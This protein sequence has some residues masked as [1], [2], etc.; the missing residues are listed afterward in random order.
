MLQRTHV[1][2]VW[3]GCLVVLVLFLGA[4][5]AYGQ[6]AEPT[7][8]ES[9]PTLRKAFTASLWGF[10]ASM[11]ADVATSIRVFRLSGGREANPIL[12]WAPQKPVLFTVVMTGQTVAAEWLLRK[13]YRDRPRLASMT[14]MVLAGLHGWAAWH[15]VRVK[16]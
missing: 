9:A 14:A 5:R 2:R 15:N 7:R 8:G 4:L 16:R 3:I 12:S 13:V 6:S 11:A 10:R 1:R